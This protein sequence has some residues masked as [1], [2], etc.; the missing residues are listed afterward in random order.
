MI[1]YLIVALTTAD[2]GSKLEQQVVME[3]KTK[4][5][6]S[7]KLCIAIHI[8][9]LENCAKEI[10]MCSQLYIGMFSGAYIVEMLEAPD[11]KA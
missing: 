6:K 7:H 9:L 5:K 10:W 3:F 4:T 1:Y 8:S 2:W 11:V